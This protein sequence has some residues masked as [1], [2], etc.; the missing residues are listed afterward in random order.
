MLLNQ[1]LVLMQSDA[2]KLSAI[3]QQLIAERGHVL[4]RYIHSE[5][6]QDRQDNKAL[7]DALAEQIKNNHNSI[8]EMVDNINLMLGQ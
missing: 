2:D 1:N 3:T 6:V 5:T 4:L 8:N 7:L